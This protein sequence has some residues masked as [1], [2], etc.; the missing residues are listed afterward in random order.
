MLDWVYGCGWWSKKN[1][2]GT[3][4]DQSILNA[5]RDVIV[6]GNRTLPLW[7]DE[8]DMFRGDISSASNDGQ[9]INKSE[10]SA[11]IQDKTVIHNKYGATYTFYCF[12]T[13]TSDPFGYT[14]K[15]WNLTH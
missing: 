15:A 14:Q 4:A 8:H 13:P 12:P 1:Q 3:C 11:Y 5:V 10:R 9:I 6:N 2:S 7:I